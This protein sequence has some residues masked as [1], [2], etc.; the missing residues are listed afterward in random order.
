M[1]VFGDE[2][3]ASFWDITCG[4]AVKML[5]VA[6]RFALLFICLKFIFWLKNKYNFFNAQKAEHKLS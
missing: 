1:L 6:V 2:V 5:G 3:R 4:C